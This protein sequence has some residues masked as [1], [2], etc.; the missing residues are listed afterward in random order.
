MQLLNMLG[1]TI[2]APP[3]AATAPS[4]QALSQDPVVIV[5][6]PRQDATM[7]EVEYTDGST[8]SQAEA[9]AATANSLP[10]KIKKRISKKDRDA[11]SGKGGAG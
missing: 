9:A 7:E 1:T 2:E 3:Q 6:E 10:T 8:D 4:T 5:D 11:K